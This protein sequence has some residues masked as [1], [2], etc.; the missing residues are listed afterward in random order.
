[1]SDSENLD[2]ASIQAELVGGGRGY[3]RNSLSLIALCQG[4]FVVVT[5]TD[6]DKGRKFK[7]EEILEIFEIFNR[8]VDAK[9]GASP[10]QLR[11]AV[12]DAIGE[13]WIVSP[14]THSND[15]TPFDLAM[16]VSTRI[17]FHLHVPHWSFDETRMR[18]KTQSPEK[19]F[20]DL[21]WLS[22]NGVS[23]KPDSFCITD[24]DSDKENYL[25][26]LYIRV[27][28]GQ[29]WTRIIIDPEIEN[30]GGGP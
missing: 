21:D 18:F 1:M 25:Y 12:I 30:N 11:A 5:G 16:K 3:R 24:Q 6:G 15:P 14:P 19:Q 2:D 17:V 29:S 28:Q 22:L 27:D 20:S 23:C 8:T 13:R 7:D 10:D 26:D 4:A 9:T